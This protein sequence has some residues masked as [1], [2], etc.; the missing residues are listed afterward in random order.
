MSKV[1]RSCNECMCLASGFSSRGGDVGGSA[2]ERLSAPKA[3]LLS[4]RGTG[5]NE[6]GQVWHYFDEVLGYSISK[7]VSSGGKVIAISGAL[8]NFVDKDDWALAAYATD[9]EKE[10]AKK[11]REAKKLAARQDSYHDQERRGISNS[12]PGA[13]IRNNLDTSHPLAFGL[14][15]T[16]HS[17]KTTRQHY[18]LLNG[19]WNVVT[20]PNDYTSFGFIGAKL[21][22]TFEGTASFAVEE[23]GRGQVVYMVDNP[24]F[25]GFW[26]NGLLLFSNALFLL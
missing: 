12:V 1:L 23:K 14:G 26:E 21:R 19:A 18:A 11:D 25:R 3:L 7:F 22:P 6:V 5:A 2:F 8:G 4:G 13:I 24:L 9:E 20:V 10:A 15:D 16:Y 17:L